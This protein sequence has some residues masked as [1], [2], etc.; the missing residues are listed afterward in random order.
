[1]KYLIISLLAVAGI[2]LYLNK[3]YAQIF[4]FLN[5]NNPGNPTTNMTFTFPSPATSTKKLIYVALGDSLTAGVGAPTEPGSYPYR[6]AELLAKKENAE[7]TLIN[8]GQPGSTSADVLTQQVAQVASYH[9]DVV[10]LLIG[11]NDLH[12]GV[13][14]KIFRDNLS[15]IIDSLAGATSH[16]NILTIPYIGNSAAFRPPY[17]TYFDLQTRR[18]NNLLREALSEPSPPQRRGQG[19]VS[20]IDLY[21]L[22]HERALNDAD[23][24]SPDGFHPSAAAY[25]FWSKIIYDHLNY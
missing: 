4:V 21:S 17:R 12:R 1:M 9:P 23:Y 11:V 20:L 13:P 3:S 24:Y 8:L 22:T 10:T 16:L 25:D 14:E 19:E 18:Y 6:L 5:A 7:V 2:I 15:A